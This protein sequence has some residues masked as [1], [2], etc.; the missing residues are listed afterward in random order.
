MPGLIASLG[1]AGRRAV[2]FLSSFVTSI[3]NYLSARSRI[4]LLVILSALPILVLAVYNGFQQR[5]A[6]ELTERQH[7]QLIAGLTA[8]RP[9]QMIEGARQLLF[10]ATADINDLLKDKASCALQ[11]RKIVAQVQGLYRTVG[12]I[13]PN[14]DIYCN[15]TTAPVEPNV[16]VK[17]RDY[18]QL[19]MSSGK[20]AVGGYQIG[21][22]TGL[23]A[24]NLA[25]PV[26]DASGKVIA[27][28][29]AA[30]NLG[31]FDEQSE[32][33][34]GFSSRGKDRVVTIADH[35]G[36]VLAQFP[37]HHATIG[38]KIRN[39]QVLQSVM[40]QRRGVFSVLDID[41]NQ[42]LFAFDSVGVNPDGKPQVRVLISTAISEI[43]D[44]ANRTLHKTV[45]IVVGM[46][47]LLLLLAWY[48]AE[49]FFTRRFRILLAMT[50]RVRAGDFS[51]RSGFGEGREELNQLGVALDEMANELQNRDKLLQD[52]LERLRSQAITDELTG[53][54]NRRHLWNALE[55]ELVRARRK[56]MPMAVMLFDIDHFKALNDQWG[57]EAGDM[58]LQGI[59]RVVRRVVR[60]TD[61][62]ARHGGE[63]FV[64]VMPEAS[65]EVALLRARELRV[66]IAEMSVNYQGQSLG[67]IT[68]SIGVAVSAD[69][70]QSGE[71][72]VREA[73]TAMYEA[74]TRGR[75]QVVV[76]KVP[77][78][79]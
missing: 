34:S 61:I 66:R 30:L 23:P 2:I 21:R 71:L 75:D 25:Q 22:F 50:A 26:L 79:P 53:L 12:I 3:L 46:S 29:Y 59:A 15:A 76:R 45:M 14:G 31:V 48:G 73:D 4:V 57:H 5:A 32:L 1:H 55:A 40:E 16:N 10:A 56:R 44:D 9:E 36:V 63:E 72:L 43:N 42:R 28:A 60:G 70:S 6:A 65:E 33:R 77:A 8:R 49:I 37:T 41:G 38:Q 78:A 39:P 69:A 52:A 51:A 67:K 35:N 54:F 11:V 58:V 47:V 62:V 18:F 74:K 17:D 13:L 7:L 68:V 24:I 20:F 27:I 19:A 64:V